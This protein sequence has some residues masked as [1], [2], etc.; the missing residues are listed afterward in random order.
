M[1]LQTA[2]DALGF[3]GATHA[4]DLFYAFGTEG[5]LSGIYNSVPANSVERR[6]VNELSKFY[7]NFISYG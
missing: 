3:P 5:M 2:A 6:L 1:R 7:T 4:D